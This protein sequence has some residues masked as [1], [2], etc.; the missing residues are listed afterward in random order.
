M[1]QWAH[2]STPNE[3]FLKALA[4]RPS[5]SPPVVKD[6]KEGDEEIMK[7]QKLTEE[8]LRTVVEA[9]GSP[10]GI[11]VEE[12]LVPV[13]TPPG[14]IK[15]RVYTPQSEDSSEIFPV[16]ASAKHRIVVVNVD[17]RLAPQFPFPTGIE[18]SY[19][20]VKWVEANAASLRVD[21]KKGFIVGG[22][23]AGGNFT[24]VITQRA[25]SDP[26]LQGK[27]TGQILQIPSTVTHSGGYPE[28]FK[29]KMISYEQNKDD[30]ILNRAYLALFI[31]A[32]KPGP[33]SDVRVSPLL[34]ESFEGLPPAYVQ[35]AGADVLR[36]EGLLYEQFMR[37]A[38]VPTKLDVY[39][40]VPHGFNTVYPEL[41][42]SEKWDE[43]FHA[44]TV[45]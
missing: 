6:P 9:A 42:I 36:D 18:D 24:C 27:L 4:E 14:E 1:A 21:L 35:I 28:K 2:Y 31:G 33:Q 44:A 20:A 40:G 39:T 16:A 23:S 34:A 30:P 43:D 10:E 3:E 37:E 11:V 15:V 32:Y 17:Y 26:V 25:R 45:N 13:T 29:D 12:K 41:R 22:K 19:E 5:F 8:R 7:Q 38:G